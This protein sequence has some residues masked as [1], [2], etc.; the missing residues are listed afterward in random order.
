MAP[1]AP[2][3]KLNRLKDYAVALGGGGE[4]RSG[5]APRPSFLWRYNHP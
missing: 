4:E 3:E 1:R 2:P 5:R